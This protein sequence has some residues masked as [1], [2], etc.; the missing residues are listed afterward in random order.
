M[1]YQVHG[2][3]ELTR[4]CAVL[5][6]TLH[7]DLLE[8]EMFAISILPLG[9][10]RLRDTRVSM[11]SECGLWVYGYTEAFTNPSI[12]SFNNDANSPEPRKLASP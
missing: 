2:L 11:Y 8:D 10:L 6:N 3:L 4:I 7:E 12:H 1:R 9:L 5:T